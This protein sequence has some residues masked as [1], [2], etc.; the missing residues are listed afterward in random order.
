LDP[1]LTIRQATAELGI[2]ESS[3]YKMR[4]G[5][6]SG[7]GSIAKRIMVPP[8]ES[9]YTVTFTDGT[10]TASR[11][12]SVVGS[13]SRADALVM[14]HDPRTRRAVVRQLR[15]EERGERRRR[16]GSPTWKRQELS[17]LRITGVHQPRQ[18]TTEAAFVIHEFRR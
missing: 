10:R 9:G 18:A 14:R 8:K 13:Q 12:I 4:A 17:Q 1:T 2:S 15:A 5:T 16:L 11:N 7:R 3:F 6:R